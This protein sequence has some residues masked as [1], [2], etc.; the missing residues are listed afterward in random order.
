MA[1]AGC[2]QELY[3][4]KHLLWNRPR[5]IQGSFLVQLIQIL[6]VQNTVF[7]PEDPAVFW[8]LS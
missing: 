6:S 1:R 4:G 5:T 3:H 8:R 2:Y 7:A